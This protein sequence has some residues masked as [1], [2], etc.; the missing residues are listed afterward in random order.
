MSKQILVI[1]GSP[2][3]QGNSDML[4]DAFIKGAVSGGN[5]ADKF[6]SAFNNING[7]LGCNGCWSKG[8]FPCVQEDDFNEKLEP[9]LERA[10]ILVFCTPLY[11]FTFPAQIKAPIDRLFPYGKENR[12]KSLKIKESALLICGADDVEATF[13]ATIQS[14]RYL[15]GYYK[16][17][18]RAE[19][20]VTNVNEKGDVLKT[21]W[22][23][24]AEM[25]GK[26]FAG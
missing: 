1:T 14:Y 11:S 19:L 21:D 22:L 25:L 15:I 16:W 13:G 4:A 5:K 20:I 18:S 17:A 9:L 8:G 6:M 24:Q 23:R 3:K 12:I 10:D 7:C 26:S 2:R